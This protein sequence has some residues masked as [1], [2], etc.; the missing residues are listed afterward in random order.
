MNK[1]MNW[2]FEQKVSIQALILT[3][4]IFLT[5]VLFMV[6]PS[7]GYVVA[8]EMGSFIGLMI[9]IFIFIFIFNYFILRK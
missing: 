2:F 3:L 9:N 6:I 7:I 5:L 4:L 1:F 8:G